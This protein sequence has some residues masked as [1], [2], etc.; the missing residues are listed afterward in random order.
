MTTTVHDPVCHMD[1]DPN[2]A[3]SKSEYNGQTYY[4]CSLGCK[5]SFDENPDK[6]LQAHRH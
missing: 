2:T 4:F 1:I 3:A 6:Y 5:K